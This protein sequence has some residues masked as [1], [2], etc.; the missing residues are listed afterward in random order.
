MTTF[1]DLKLSSQIL[2]ALDA[3]GY[4]TPTPIQAKAIPPLLEGRDVL[5]C[6]QTGTGKT[7]AFSLPLI[8]RLSATRRGEIEGAAKSDSTE[9]PKGSSKG[10]SRRARALILA[11]TRELAVQI[12]ESIRT[13]GRHCG[14]RQVVIYGGVSQSRQTRALQAGVD[15]IVATP[16]RLLDLM[17]Q[18]YV[19]LSGIRFFVLDEADRMLDMGF[20]EP[21][22]RIGRQ[23]PKERQTLLFS[24]TMPANIRDLAR[25]MLKDPVTVSVTPVASAAPLIE[26]TLYHVPGEQKPSLLAHLLLDAKITRAVVFTKTKHGAVKLAK[27]LSREGTAAD[28]IHGNKSQSQ[29]QRALDAFRGGR[30]RVLVATDVAA[31][32]LDVDG[33]SHVFNYNLPMEPEA[34]VH[35]IG[36]TGRAGATGH[37]ISFCSGDERGLLRAIERLGG[38]PIPASKLPSDFVPQH[39]PLE[40]GEHVHEARSDRPGAS[41]RHRSTPPATKKPSGKPHGGH[42][43]TEKPRSDHS[44]SVQGSSGAMKSGRPPGGNTHP[45]AA[46]K[47]SGKPTPKP[48]HGQDRRDA[49]KA[50][51]K[52]GMKQGTKSG[53]GHGH[54]PK[55]KPHSSARR[56][57]KGFSR[58]SSR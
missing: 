12:E 47:H 57:G 21:I 41:P 35:R 58:T 38:K 13:Y 48:T 5:G 43:H 6:A 8:D 44:P 36:R 1:A 23:L 32:G 14:L 49:G 45:H 9:R 18:G 56:A 31:R 15:V 34:Y 24:A 7:A 30:A 52:P 16:G 3:E 46:P 28:S 25:A 53:Q 37:A 26:Q 39:T 33:I 50:G 42:A 2:K 17:E 4:H 51:G 29:R 19:D 54:H 55:A 10:D 27:R 20:I 40:R 11:P 22:R